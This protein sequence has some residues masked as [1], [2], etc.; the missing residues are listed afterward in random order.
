MPM[1]LASARIP[2]PQCRDG[3]F[4]LSRSWLRRPDANRCLRPA[5]LVGRTDSRQ[6]AFAAGLR[7][8]KMDI[9][10]RKLAAG[11]PAAA[12]AASGFVVTHL[13]RARRRGCGMC[14]EWLGPAPLDRHPRAQPPSERDGDR[15]GQVAAPPCE[16]P[17]AIY[18]PTLYVPSERHCVRLWASAI[19]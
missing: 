11:R 4:E 12:G 10:G 5:R 19:V 2:R 8:L 9:T 14:G 17:A 16:T 6:R 1:R 18:N 3:P 15:A 13:Q 7:A